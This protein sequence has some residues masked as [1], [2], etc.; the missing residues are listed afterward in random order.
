MGQTSLSSWQPL[1]KVLYPPQARHYVAAL[2][3][4]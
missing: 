4:Y 3:E 1:N 2:I